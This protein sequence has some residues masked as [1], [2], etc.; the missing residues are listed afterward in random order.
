MVTLSRTAWIAGGLVARLLMIAFLAMTV[1]LTVNNQTKFKY[2]DD[3]YKLESYS[4]TVAVA[5]IGMAGSLLQIPVS[6]YLL[7]KSKRMTP[8]TLVL[9]I[10]MYADVVMVTVLLATGVGAGFGATVDALRFVRAPHTS[11]TGG[12]VVKQDFIHYYNKAFYPVVFLLT[13]MVLSMAAT[14]ASARLRARA[15][16]E[17]ADV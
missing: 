16:N 10:S 17:D 8:S 11:W 12:D 5:S 15:A 3:F 4:Y 9:D 1:Q 2:E 14:V 7:C 6:V 13:G